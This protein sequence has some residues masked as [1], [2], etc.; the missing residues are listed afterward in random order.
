VAAAVV[1]IG[2]VAL[3]L[4]LNSGD[5]GPAAGDTEPTSTPTTPTGSATA[6][7]TTSP[8][9]APTQGTPV[10]RVITL[11]HRPGRSHRRPPRARLAPDS[12]FPPWDG[13]S[14]V[15]Y[16]VQTGNTI[17]LGPGAQPASFNP[18]ETMAAFAAGSQFANGTRYF[19][20]SSRLASGARSGRG[21]WRCLSPT[22]S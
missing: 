3:V 20:S 18:D 11:D 2:V 7:A 14:T 5:D 16:D 9:A 13:V 10:A 21:G 12:V 1:G 4:A 8:T 6:D 22:E 17:E 15:I 19:S